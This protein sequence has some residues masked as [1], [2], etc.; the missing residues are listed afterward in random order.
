MIELEESGKWSCLVTKAEEVKSVHPLQRPSKS[1][2]IST[3]M[4]L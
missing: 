2:K 4:L 1:L 3:A